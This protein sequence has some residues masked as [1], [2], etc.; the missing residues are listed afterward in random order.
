MEVVQQEGLTAGAKVPA[1]SLQIDRAGQD[2]IVVPVAG[3]IGCRA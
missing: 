2:G 3:L 1:G